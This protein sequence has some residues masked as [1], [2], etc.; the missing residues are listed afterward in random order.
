MKNIFVYGTLKRDFPNYN[1]QR[2]AAG[3]R[4]KYKTVKPYALVIADQ[5]YVP[6]L[7]KDKEGL[8]TQISGELYQVD[9][10]T[11]IWLDQL[12]GIGKPKGYQRLEIEV[13]NSKGKIAKADVYMK[14]KKDLDSIHEELTISYPLDPRYIAPHLRQAIN[15]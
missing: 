1:P 5:Y 3:Y 11:L 13:I 15:K 7:L 10:Q 9:P 4:G 8:R 6:V 2:L 14:D 12:E